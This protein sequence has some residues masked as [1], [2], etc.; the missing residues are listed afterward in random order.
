MEQEAFRFRW[1]LLRREG[2]SVFLMAGMVLLSEYLMGFNGRQLVAGCLFISGIWLVGV[3]DC[4]YGLIF[5]RFLLSMGIVGL[6]LD[7]MG[8]LVS[9]EDAAEGAFLGGALL[10]LVREASH[11]GMGGGDVKYAFVLGLWMGGEKLMLALFLA[12]LSG[13]LAALFLTVRRSGRDRIPFGPFLSLG[14][15][16]SFFYGSRILQW[17]EEMFP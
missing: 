3:M 17:Y 2:N 4:R 16:I 1:E 12:F 13:S 11:G 14:G 15:C 7:V 5:D 9:P 8:W 10:F 6:A